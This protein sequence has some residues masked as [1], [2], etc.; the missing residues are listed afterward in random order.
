MDVWST[1]VV[2]Y[3]WVT[4]RLPFGGASKAH[5]MELIRNARF[6]IPKTVSPALAELIRGCLT[7]DP[8]ER[9]TIDR[10]M[11]HPWMTAPSVP[12]PAV[13]RHTS[14]DTFSRRGSLVLEMQQEVR[15][16]P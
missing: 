6:A 10:I 9:F 15:A 8:T 3:A 11:R 16:T 2:L 7:V 13:P 4:G 1:G 5:T 12:N 14:A